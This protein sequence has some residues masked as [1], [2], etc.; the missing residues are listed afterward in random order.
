MLLDL[1]KIRADHR[2]SVGHEDDS[3]LV[4][5]STDDDT[6]A[7][8]DSIEID[9][10]DPIHRQVIRQQ[11]DM[12]LNTIRAYMLQK[13]NAG[14][15]RDMALIQQAEGAERLAARAAIEMQRKYPWL[16]EPYPIA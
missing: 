8:L 3:P 14:W 15:M 2:N 10:N 11:Y 6:D 7:L 12:L 9:G 16:K 13:Q 1:E 4:D 5:A